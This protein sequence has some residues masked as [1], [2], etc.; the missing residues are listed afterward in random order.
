VLGDNAAAKCPSKPRDGPEERSSGSLPPQ[1]YRWPLASWGA[2]RLLPRNLFR[3][4]A[5][6]GEEVLIARDP[7]LRT[8]SIRQGR[9]EK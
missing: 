6:S 7:G 4:S 1:R 9:S 5:R 3:M 8:L 2:A